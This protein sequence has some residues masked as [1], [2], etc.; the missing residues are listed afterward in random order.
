MSGII[1]AEALFLSALQ[2]SDH[3]GFE[4]IEAA[5]R[6]TFTRHGGDDGCAADCAAEYGDHPELAVKRMRWALASAA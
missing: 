3:P 6:N 4:Q 2:P 1:R 5:I